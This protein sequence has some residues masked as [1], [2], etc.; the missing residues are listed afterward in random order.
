MALPT[1][2]NGL[3]RLLKKEQNE[4][5]KLQEQLAKVKEDNTMLR[6]KLIAPPPPPVQSPSPRQRGDD[7]KN[8][9]R[10]RRDAE[11][12]E[13][14]QA[15]SLLMTNYDS[16]ANEM[17]SLSGKWI[18]TVRALNQ[19]EASLGAS[20]L[21]P[22]P[23]GTV[24]WVFTDVQDS[25]PLWEISPQVMQL[26]LNM[27]N[28]LMRKKILEHK[29]YEIRTQGDSFVLAF[30]NPIDAANFCIDIQ[31]QLMEVKWDDA[32]LRMHKSTSLVRDD[33][34][35]IVFNGL[36]VRMGIHTGVP[37]FC[38]RDAT[39]KRMDYFGPAMNLAARVSGCGAG[40]QVVVSSQAMKEI[41][42]CSEVMDKI[43]IKELG[44]FSLKGVEQQQELTQI[45]PL[46]LA[47][48]TFPPI[49]SASSDTAKLV[50]DLKKMKEESE[51][52][53]NE[54]A[55]MKEALASAQE[56]VASVHNLLQQIRRNNM[57]DNPQAMLDEI[58]NLIKQQDTMRQMVDTTQQQTLKFQANL[59]GIDERVEA[60]REQHQRM[61][62]V[63]IAQLHSLLKKVVESI[64]EKANHVLTLEED[65]PDEK[66]EIASILTDLTTLKAKIEEQIQSGDT[67]EALTTFNMEMAPSRAVGSMLDLANL[68]YSAYV[69]LQTLKDLMLKQAELLRDVP[70]ITP[71]PIVLAPAKTPAKTTPPPQTRK[72]EEDPI[73][74]MKNYLIKMEEEMLL[75]ER[76]KHMEGANFQFLGK[77]VV[78]SWSGE[79]L[80]V[81]LGGGFQQVDTWAKQFLAHRQAR[82]NGLPTSSSQNS[83][84]SNSNNNN[85]NTPQTHSSPTTTNNSNAPTT[86]L[87]SPRGGGST[88]VLPPLKQ[89]SQ[90]S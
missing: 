39:S 57:S 19:Y 56:R 35:R 68:R 11:L 87:K 75:P 74:K 82:P 33:S 15:L 21:V 79:R 53:L 28:K 32:L 13:L 34:D 43:E 10:D 55:K 29:A 25:T 60:L 62:D 37:D 45:S 1:D 3:L 47:H 72:K 67:C 64:Q 76:F 50:A 27:H 18:Q 9:E 59:G 63:T 36:R 42:E 78:M 30:Q 6:T 77:K 84:K 46:A 58:D 80:G 70:K 44:K 52:V 17:Q 71:P 66:F 4:M 61:V 2:Y 65:L 7:N 26:A 20:D 83:N 38:E 89:R 86:R 22:P 54:M 41:R 51:A 69:R 48:R 8:N 12:K 90:T 81:R 24:S 31:G 88:P 16:M 23:Q 73:T 85:D 14:S 49:V 40:G 5:K